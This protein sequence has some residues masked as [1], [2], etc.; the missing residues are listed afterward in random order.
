MTRKSPDCPVRENGKRTYADPLSVFP[1]ISHFIRLPVVNGEC[2][3][4]PGLTANHCTNGLPIRDIWQLVFATAKSLIF[5][6][7][8]TRCTDVRLCMSVL[9]VRFCTLSAMT[10]QAGSLSIFLST[11]QRVRLPVVKRRFRTGSALAAKGTNT[12][13]RL[14]LRLPPTILRSGPT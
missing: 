13:S 3:T 6:N 11:N 12:D 8:L 10:P 2:R 9:S 14:G 7:Q 1:S 5:M 4:V